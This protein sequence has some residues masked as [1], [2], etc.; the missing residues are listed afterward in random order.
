MLN[1]TQLK[2][3]LKSA[4]SNIIPSAIEI[5]MRST[6]TYMNDESQKLCEEFAARFDDMVSDPLAERL[7]DII[8]QYVK[9]MCIYGTVLTAGSPVTQTAIINP[10]GAVNVANPIA[11][12]VPNT[13]GVM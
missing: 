6:F 7:A 12:K 1:P 10:G 5:C 4:L 2:S 3:D 9:S 13:L 11:G 8:D